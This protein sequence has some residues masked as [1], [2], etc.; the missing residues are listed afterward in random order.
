MF[1]INSDPYIYN[2]AIGNDLPAADRQSGLGN[3]AL[4]NLY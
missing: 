3:D 2:V 1:I 4:C